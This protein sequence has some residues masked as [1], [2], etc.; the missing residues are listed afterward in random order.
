MHSAATTLRRA[1]PS[2]PG[3]CGQA[4]S[5]SATGGSASTPKQPRATR[6]R[7]RRGHALRRIR[8]AGWDP[9]N[10]GW[11]P[12][13]SPRA[14]LRRRGVAACIS[15]RR[16]QCGS[17]RVISAALP[18]AAPSVA[19]CRPGGAREAAP[20]K[21][22]VPALEGDRDEGWSGAVR[23]S[24]RPRRDACGAAA[25]IHW[26]GGLLLRLQTSVAV[27]AERDQHGIGRKAGTARYAPS[28]QA[29]QAGTR[30]ILR[31]EQ[32]RTMGSGE[33]SEA[34]GRDVHRRL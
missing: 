3:R 8:P 2:R 33:Q 1:G 30:P 19:P 21:V 9:P 12:S 26:A 20:G 14:T 24:S 13:H 11:P 4:S 23:A 10:S 28:P 27:A 5:S 22:A 29:L 34:L 25:A 17:Q 32:D 31:T 18:A 7:R 16:A 15:P 6:Q